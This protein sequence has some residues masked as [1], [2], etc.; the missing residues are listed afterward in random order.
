[1]KS[2]KTLLLL[3]FTNKREPLAT[4]F[5]T[6]DLQESHA[7]CTDVWGTVQDQRVS[8]S[9]RKWP[10]AQTEYV[11]LKMNGSLAAPVNWNV[12]SGQVETAT[13]YI[14]AFT[15][16]FP[17]CENGRY[18]GVKVWTKTLREVLCLL[19]ND[20]VS[21]VVVM[22]DPE[23]FFLLLDTIRRKRSASWVALL[24]ANHKSSPGTKLHIK[25]LRS[26]FIH[27]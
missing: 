22:S 23:L 5:L 7:E 14:C 18:F 9:N 4:C 1:M 12:V 17:P 8:E 13:S 20:S 27:T 10:S 6:S 25:L 21:S 15:S 11:C 26:L 19:W 3:L 24:K 16:D 2:T